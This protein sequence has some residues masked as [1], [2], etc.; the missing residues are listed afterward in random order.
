M[1]IAYYV[2]GH[3][4]GHISRSEIIIRELLKSPKVEKI[5]LTTK[6]KN[7]IQEKLERVE[8]REKNLDPEMVQNSSISL[9][10]GKTKNA[11]LE[12]EIKKEK[13]KEEEKL[14]LREN[15]VDLVVSDS[16][17]L[18]FPIARDLGV[19]SVFIGN[20]T[21]D[22]IY[23]NYEKHD[24]FYQSYANSIAKEY[25]F[26]DL[27][28]VL[29]FHCPMDS[30]PVKKNVGLVGREPTLSRKEVR[31]IL[32]FREDLKY[33]LFSFGAYGIRESDL[34]LDLLKQDYRIVISGYEGFQSEKILKIENVMYADLIRAC[35]FVVT[36]PGYGILAETYFANTPVIYTDRG[37]FAEY[38]YLVEAMNH[39]HEAYYISHEELFQLNFQEAVFDKIDTKKQKIRNK[40]ENGTLEIASEIVNIGGRK[41]N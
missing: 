38:P 7:F 34:R 25:S 27:S 14:F 41:K 31:K 20:F 26:C 1:K 29:P 6:R 3:G 9:D 8:V 32:H 24:E 11:I 19:F 12:F 28:F 17:S 23:K 35:D 4:F 36:K 13:L 10:I 33:F 18:P 22:F 39:Y 37:D 40:L 16:P 5:F 15:S 21:W 30:L 2:S